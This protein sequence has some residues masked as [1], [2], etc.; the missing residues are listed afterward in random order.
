MGVR[1]YVYCLTYHENVRRL[2]LS[3]NQ[4]KNFWQSKFDEIENS[5]HDSREFWNSWEN[6]LHDS[7]EFWNSWENSLHDSREFWNSW[8]N[9]LH[10]SREF[11]NS[12]ENASEYYWF[13][14]RADTTARQYFN[15]VLNLHTD[16]VGDKVEGRNSN[17]NMQSNA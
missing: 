10:D 12:W 6:S 1:K 7:R 2:N 3:T 11:W 15:H 9:S 17:V 14:T 13:D 4:K 5:L 8:E 16:T